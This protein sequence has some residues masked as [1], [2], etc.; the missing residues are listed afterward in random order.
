MGSNTRIVLVDEEDI[1]LE[2]ELRADVEAAAGRLLDATRTL[3]WGSGDTF[4]DSL[5]WL[6]EAAE[7]RGHDTSVTVWSSEIRSSPPISGN[8]GPGS[9]KP[10]S[11]H[12]RLHE[13]ADRQGGW[14]CHVCRV[15]LVDVCSDADIELDRF[16]K[17]MV[18]AAC[19]KR[20]PTEDHV[21][22]RQLNGSNSLRNLA[23][24][25]QPCN[26]RKGSA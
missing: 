11:R 19:Q 12:M 13:L 25:C 4:I 15:G 8:P 23:L 10:T 9:L 6:M 26:T 1:R 17:R 14:F 22:P 24:S 20:L 16:G 2:E 21:V 18:R 5:R 3:G 7:R